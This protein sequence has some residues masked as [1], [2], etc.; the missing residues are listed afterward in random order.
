V[1]TLS[2]IGGTTPT[3]SIAS[4]SPESGTPGESIVITGTNFN[5][6]TAVSFNDTPAVFTINSDT[7]I[8]A[9]VPATASKGAISISSASGTH[10]STSFFTVNPIITLSQLSYTYDGLPKSVQ[11][12]TIP[13]NLPVTITY[14]NLSALPVNAGTYAVAASIHNPNYT[15]SVEAT[16]VIRKAPAKIVFSQLQQTFNGLAKPVAVTTTP[17]G[18]AAEI[19]YSNAAAPINAGSYEVSAMIKDANFEGSATG[20]LQVNKASQTI[21]FEAPD[22]KMFGDAAFALTA[23]ASSQM[24]VQFSVVKGAAVVINNV[25]NITG[26]GEITIRA[27]Q[28]G[29]ENF[30]EAAAIEK[31]IC[32]KPAKPVITSS[33]THPALFI[34]T[35]SSTLGNEWLLNGE[36]IADATEQTYQVSKPG[37]YA[38]RVAI[39]G[40]SNIS[41]EVI[42]TGTHVDAALDASIRLFPNPASDK[43]AINVNGLPM[44]GAYT[45]TVYNIL[46]EKVA[47][48]TMD[49]QTDRWQTELIISHLSAG[50]YIVHVTDGRQRSS[51]AFVKQ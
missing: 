47:E 23:R 40:C 32:I 34:L 38:V 26:A 35:S 43:I 25:V 21:T 17:A 39:H 4:F 20:T 36:P 15:G 9:T 30:L 29:N 12:S 45:A 28:A 5:G 6:A 27:T 31:T 2:C 7:Q 18:L 22:D 16:L 13:A 49:Y 44:S 33:Q 51:K 46:G 42:L 41:D 48:K 11:V 1:A 3:P 14:N 10:Q 37:R 50:H 19:M 24:P 8:T